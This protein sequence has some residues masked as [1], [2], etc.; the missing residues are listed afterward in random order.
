MIG[1]GLH[2]PNVTLVG[3]VLADTTLTIPDFRSSEKT[4][5]LLTQVAGRSGR[6]KPGEVIIQTYLPEHYAIQN[7]L[8]HDYQGFYQQ[9]LT[10]RQDAHYP[11]FNKL[12]KLTIEDTDQQKAYF[13]AHQLFSELQQYQQEEQELA[14][15]INVF[16]ALLPKLK[17]RYRWQILI[18]GQNPQL[19]LQKFSSTQPLKSDIK[20]DVDPLHTI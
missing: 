8:R 7:T 6:E 13:R 5:Q 1:K 17:N 10:E 16:P 15:Q 19:L 18:G 12:V 9:E 20:I 3:V 2:L 4:F 14:D 11:P